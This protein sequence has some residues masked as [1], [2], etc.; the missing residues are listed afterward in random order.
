MLNVKLA[1]FNMKSKKYSQF[2]INVKSTENVE[3]KS[4]NPYCTCHNRSCNEVKKT[5]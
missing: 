3:G 1:T 4:F 2:I 5:E